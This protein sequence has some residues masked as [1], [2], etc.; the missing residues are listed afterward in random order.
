METQ[1]P[2]ELKS[3][4]KI[5]GV[6]YVTIFS[7]TRTPRSFADNLGFQKGITELKKVDIFCKGLARFGL[8]TWLVRVLNRTSTIAIFLDGVSTIAIMVVMRVSYV[9]QVNC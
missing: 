1:L 6:H 9:M 8:T 2:V 4:M 3:F 5:S 7:V